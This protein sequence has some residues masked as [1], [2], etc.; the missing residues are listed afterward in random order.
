MIER[1]YQQN[2]M[3][4]RE[5]FG[6]VTFDEENFLW[7]I[8]YSFNL[9][10]F[11]DQE[12]TILMIETPGQHINNHEAFNFYANKG[13]TRSDMAFYEHIYEEESYNRYSD[14]GLSRLSLHLETFH[15]SYDVYSGDTLLDVTQNVY[16]FL[17]L[18][19]GL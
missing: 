8:I 12:T 3:V 13:L 17:A 4:L 11:Y 6:K 5:V 19:K 7:L 2:I 14:Y 18:R 9:P 16:N 15:P 10:E 1:W